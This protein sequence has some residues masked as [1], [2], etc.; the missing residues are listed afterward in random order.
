MKRVEGMHEQLVNWARWLSDGNGVGTGYPRAST[1]CRDYVDRYHGPVESTIPIDAVQAN[2]MHEAIQS[3]QLT[4]SHLHLVIV[5]HYQ[6]AREIKQVAQRMLK[7]PATVK[8]YLAQADEALQAWLRKDS[9]G[10]R[11]LDGATGVHT[12]ALL[13]VKR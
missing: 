8:L 13:G 10:K 6:H 4:Q 2:K 11:R 9:R 12:D 1:Y 5:H 3:L 7:S